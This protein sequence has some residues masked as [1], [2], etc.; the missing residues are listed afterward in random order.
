[1]EKLVIE[2]GRTLQGRVELSGA[3][4]AALPIITATLLASGVHKI[5]NVPRLRDIRTM[6][7]LLEILGAGVSPDAHTLTID[8]S[9][10]NSTEA[11]YELVK[12]RNP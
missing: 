2:G 11:P 7:R 3:K 1:M 5:T 8:T 6:V 10:A 9:S 12:T 4:N